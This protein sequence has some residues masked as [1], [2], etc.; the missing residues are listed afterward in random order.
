MKTRNGAILALLLP[1]MCSE[2]AWEPDSPFSLNTESSER[3]LGTVPASESA[4]WQSR[5]RCG[6]GRW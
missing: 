1:A 5:A 2:E 3:N 4:V 6:H